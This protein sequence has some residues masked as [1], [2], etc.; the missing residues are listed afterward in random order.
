MAEIINISGSPVKSFV[1]E[2]TWHGETI[3]VA[4]M[5]GDS[6]RCIAEQVCAAV[7]S[8]GLPPIR[9]FM[10]VDWQ[11]LA[12]EAEGERFLA[13]NQDGTDAFTA[14]DPGPGFYRCICGEWRRNQCNT[15]FV[16]EGNGPR[17][18]T[19]TSAK[20]YREVTGRSAPDGVFD[21]LSHCMLVVPAAQSPNCASC[22]DI[23]NPR[24]EPTVD[25]MH[26]MCADRVARLREAKRPKAMGDDPYKLHR[27]RCSQTEEVIGDLMRYRD[28]KN[29]ASRFHADSPPP[30]EF[31]ERFGKHVWECDEGEP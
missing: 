6:A 22:G 29:G 1:Y 13:L 27:E 14:S 10:T 31:R 19:I 21:P 17:C 25:G 12:P 3:K 11:P 2:L 9:P 23:L 18:K 15:S 5:A 16:C 28:E 4:A 7:E 26:G 20:Q 8:R 30:S 24:Y